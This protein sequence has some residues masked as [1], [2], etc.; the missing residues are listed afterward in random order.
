MKIQWTNTAIGDLAD[1]RIHIAQTSPDS[2]A[3]IAERILG[4]VEVVLQYPEI[5][6]PGRARGTNELVIAG[7]SYIL[8]YRA[9]RAK[10]QIL[11]V[12]HGRRRWP[13]RRRK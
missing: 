11:R 12:L 7:T 1:L 9:F 4:A 8:V 3:E 10:V 13:P 6:K 5:G 2:A